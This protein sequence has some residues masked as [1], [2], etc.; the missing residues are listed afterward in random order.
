MSAFMCSAAHIST[1]VNAG[2]LAYIDARSMEAYLPV[3][4]KATLFALQT[5]QEALFGLLVDENMKSIGER[6][7]D[8]S[9]L[10]DW[11]EGGESEFVYDPH[12]KAPSVVAAIKLAQSYAYQSC[13]H[14]E[15]EASDAKRYIDHLI[16]GL[17]AK[18]PGYDAAEWSI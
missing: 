3:S 4:A 8:A 15:W 9:R 18:L 2:K 17:I 14:G 7:P 16:G 10:S 12:A 5:P 6:Y 1:L 11:H 13:E